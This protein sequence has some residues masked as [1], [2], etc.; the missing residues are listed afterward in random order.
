MQMPPHTHLSPLR[1]L[2]CLAIPL[3]SLYAHHHA[4]RNPRRS[5]ITLHHTANRPHNTQTI[6][7]PSLTRICTLDKLGRRIKGLL[8]LLLLHPWSS[9]VRLRPRDHRRN[10]R[11][12]LIRA[13]TL[14]AIAELLARRSWLLC[15]D[16]CCP[17]RPGANRF[18]RDPRW[19]A[20]ELLPFLPLPPW[21]DDLTRRRTRRQARRLLQWCG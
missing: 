18:Y 20:A 11:R 15:G 10:N 7:A 6:C 14:R 5:R 2:H 13:D 19:E 21:V 9:S 8:L 16:W 3:A 17:T 1:K 12:G 4:R